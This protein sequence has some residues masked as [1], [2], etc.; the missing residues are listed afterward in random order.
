MV[1]IIK[2]VSLTIPGNERY[3]HF[4]GGTDFDAGDIIDIET[5]MG[6]AAKEVTVVCGIY[7][8][9]TIRFNAMQIQYAEI[10]DNQFVDRQEPRRDYSNPVTIIDESMEPVVLNAG[11]SFTF[12]NV[13]KNIQITALTGNPEITVE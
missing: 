10:V 4:I 3:Q 1:V 11:E 6:R 13:C 12:N 2:K 5:S 8:T 7:D 9:I